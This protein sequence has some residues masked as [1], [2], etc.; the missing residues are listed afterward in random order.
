MSPVISNPKEIRETLEEDHDRNEAA[1]L[2]RA[3]D[4]LFFEIARE[5]PCGTVVTD[6]GLWLA[7]DE[8]AD[9]ERYV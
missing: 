1:N 4:G 3:P 8:F 7:P 2:Y 5:L 6:A 9:C